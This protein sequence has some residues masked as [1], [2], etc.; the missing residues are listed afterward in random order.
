MEHPCFV[1]CIR[2]TSNVDLFRQ[3]EL[4][5]GQLRRAAEKYGGPLDSNVLS[6]ALSQ[7]LEKEF[8]PLQNVNRAVR[9]L[10][11]ENNGKIDHKVRRKLGDILRV[12]ESECHVSAE[13]LTESEGKTSIS[14]EV[15]VPKEFH[16]EKY[17]STRKSHEEKKKPDSPVIPVDFLCP[18]SLEIMRDPVI[19]ATG[20]VW[21]TFSISLVFLCSHYVGIKSELFSK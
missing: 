5:R 11:L 9:S 13:I 14:T 15:S 21:F 3:V 7:L 16:I 19:V 20:Q 10:H 2:F 4:V 6:R 12:N 8:D 1:A 17:D 18:I